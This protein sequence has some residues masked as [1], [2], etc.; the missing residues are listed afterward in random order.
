MMALRPRG[1]AIK[2]NIPRILLAP[3]EFAVA[4]MFISTGLS[5]AR[6]VVKYGNHLPDTGL[7]SLPH[8]ILWGWIVA[9]IAGAICILIGLAAGL[10]RRMARAV[11]RSGLW[12]TLA[13]WATIAVG[14]MCFTLSDPLSYAQYLA[15]VLGCALR[16]Y[17]SREVEHAMTRATEEARRDDG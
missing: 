15:I 5:A 8:S 6:A 7:L 3:F 16:L 9:V 11:E 13:A 14:Q 17:A 1:Q 12:L 4:F 2:D 10:T